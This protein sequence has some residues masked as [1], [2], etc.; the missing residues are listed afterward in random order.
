[1]ITHVLSQQN[2]KWCTHEAADLFDFWLICDVFMR[3]AEN[4]CWLL[5][6]ALFKAEEAAGCCSAV[7]LLLFFDDVYVCQV[8]TVHSNQSIKNPL[9]WHVVLQ[10]SSLTYFLGEFLSKLKPQIYSNLFRIFVN[11]ASILEVYGVPNI[12]GPSRHLSHVIGRDQVGIK[13][14]T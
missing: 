3:G 10:V 11:P 7:L 12:Q 5:K 8:C 4:M 13:H 2:L 14:W 1:M 9:S 6:E